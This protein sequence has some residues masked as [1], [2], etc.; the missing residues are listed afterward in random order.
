MRKKIS[1]IVALV[2]ASVMTLAA[3]GTTTTPSTQTSEST[4]AASTSESTK[5]SEEAK[6]KEIVTITSMIYDRGDEFLAGNSLTDNAVTR[7]INEQLAPLGVKVEWVPV[8]RSGSD[9]A[10]NLMLAGGTAPD[11]IRTYDRERVSTYASQGGLV[12][13]TPYMDYLD[14]TFAEEY[15]YAIEWC[16]FDGGQ[17]A[18]PGVY[19]Y[20]GKSN[21]TFIRQDI[22]EALGEEMPTTKDELIDLFYKVKAAYPD[23]KVYGFSA[24][25]QFTMYSTWLLSETSRADER[26]NYM[27]E[28]TATIGLKPG[29]KEALK[30]LNKFYLDGIIDPAF[31]EDTD[32]SVFEQDVANG[33]VFFI[34]DDGKEA[35]DAYVTAIEENPDYRMVS[36]DCIENA[37]GNYDVPSQDA[38]SHYVYVPKTAEDR[39]EAVMTYIGWLTKEENSYQLNNGVE[40][41]GG[42]RND[43]G[44]LSKLSNDEIF[45][46]GGT[47]RTGDICF[48]YSNFKINEKNLVSDFMTKYPG[49]PEDVAEGVIASQY[50]NYFDKCLIGSSLKNDEY[51]PNLQSMIPD[52]VFKCIAAPAGQ[53]DAVYEAEYQKLV[54]NHLNDILEERGAW[55]DANVAK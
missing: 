51:V 55:Y 42:K 53:F 1:K 18:L 8:P 47:R 15:D 16:Q 38:F 23:M 30:E 21:E 46:A 50:S 52:L 26:I 45:A 37:D 54:D 40:G 3:C 25:N 11:V 2:L 5:P 22:V 31:V 44:T 13:L 14:P 9:N 48:M 10:V 17:Y 7:W 19:G 28:P 12:D 4:P 36:I 34:A 35:F 49:V 41:I 33:N 39:I 29:H 6:P 20:H 27:Y 32:M 43:D 24:K